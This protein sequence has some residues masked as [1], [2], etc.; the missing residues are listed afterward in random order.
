MEDILLSCSLPGA[1]HLLLPCIN[2]LWVLPFG[3]ATEPLPCLQ[4]CL[5]LYFFCAAW[6]LSCQVSHREFK[7]M[8]Y[9]SEWDIAKREELEQQ[10][11]CKE[12]L[13][14]ITLVCVLV[15]CHTVRIKDTLLSDLLCCFLFC[16]SFTNLYIPHTSGGVQ[17][18]QEIID[19]PLLTRW[20]PADHSTWW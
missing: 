1:Y 14:N 20:G 5:Q 18:E 19:L 2:H 10:L 16:H 4:S 6:C 9:A 12:S 13:V 7:C 8:V 17:Q 3:H 11:D 15:S